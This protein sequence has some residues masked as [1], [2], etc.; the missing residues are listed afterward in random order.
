MTMKFRYINHSFGAMQWAISIGH[1][2]ISTAVMTMSGFRA[3]PH[4]RYD[5]DC[6]KCIY[7]YL[8]KM[9][10]AEI[11]MHTEELDYSKI[12]VNE[13]DWS[14]SVYGDVKE[15]TP[16]DAPELLS[17]FVTLLHYIN[18]NLFHDMITG[19]SVT[20]ILHFLAEQDAHQL[21]C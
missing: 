14:H 20:G 12:P 21:V 1:F 7:G 11:V 2:N 9:K 5:L 16:K 18:T 4:H 13:Y 15:C 3:Q 8:H 10:D 19:H 17:K 6:I